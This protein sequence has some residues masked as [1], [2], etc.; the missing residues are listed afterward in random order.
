M[1]PGNLAPVAAL[2]V[3]DIAVEAERVIA[4]P[5][6]VVSVLVDEVAVEVNVEVVVAEEEQDEVASA[7]VDQR[8]LLLRHPLQQEEIPE[9]CS[10]L[11]QKSVFT[12]RYI[13]AN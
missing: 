7:R 3:Q 11:F 4:K 6:A 8:D 1:V 5:D 2:T 12:K 10:A 13:R 9:S